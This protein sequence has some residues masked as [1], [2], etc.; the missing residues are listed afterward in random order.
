[1]W[2]GAK[3]IL[4]MFARRFLKHA[5]PAFDFVEIGVKRRISTAAL[6][7]SID[8]LLCC[9]MLDEFVRF[10]LQHEANDLQEY[11]AK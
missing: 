6:A 5:H 2:D 4:V 9:A 10:F 11:T 3:C 1:M 8:S 7:T